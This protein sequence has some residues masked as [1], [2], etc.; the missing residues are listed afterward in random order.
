MRLLRIIWR[1][2][3]SLNSSLTLAVKI[4]G[5]IFLVLLIVFG[6]HLGSDWWN[7]PFE[8]KHQPRPRWSV[9]LLLLALGLLFYMLWV[10][11]RYRKNR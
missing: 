11:D 7:Q 3:V 5:L 8:M 6:W 10:I 9:A 1:D 2:I 4:A